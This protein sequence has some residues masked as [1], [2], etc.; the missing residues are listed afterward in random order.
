MCEAEEFFR[1]CFSPASFPTP[2]CFGIEW[3]G[4]QPCNACDCYRECGEKYLRWQKEHDATT[5]RKA[6][7]DFAK[8]LKDDVSCMGEMMDWTQCGCCPYHKV[9]D[10]GCYDCLID[11]SLRNQQEKGIA[12]GVGGV[13]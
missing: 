7:E 8:K 12:M 10:N 3:V 2:D 13:K 5:S 9:K 4:R 6:C 11:R 1:S